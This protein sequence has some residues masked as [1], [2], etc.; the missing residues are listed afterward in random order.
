ML[1]MT[2]ARLNRHTQAVGFLLM[3]NPKNVYLPNGHNRQGGTG[4]LPLYLPGNAALL[5]ALAMMAAGWDGG[6]GVYAPGF[7]KDGSFHVEFEDIR[8]YI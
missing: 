4:G 3:D 7:P 1:A 6:N 8:Q 5:L 2:A